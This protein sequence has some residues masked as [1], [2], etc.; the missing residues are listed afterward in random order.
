MNALYWP[1]TGWAVGNPDLKPETSTEYECIFRKFFG[2]TGDIK[3]VVFEKRAKDLIQWQ[4]ISPG[5]W[6]PVNVSKTRIRGF[7]T[8]GKIH[9][10]TADV[11]LSYTFMD[12]QDITADKKIRFSTRHQIKGTASVYPAKDTTVSIEWSYVTNYVVQKGDP[13]CYFLLNGK[14]SRK[15]RLSKGTAEI[16]IIGKN[17]LNRDFETITGYP[18]PPVEFSGGIDSVSDGY[19]AKHIH[20]NHDPHNGDCLCLHHCRQNHGHVRPRPCKPPDGFII[21]RNDS[22]NACCLIHTSAVRNKKENSI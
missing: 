20:L 1:D 16:F 14:L 4:E 17:I 13:E 22:Q 10:N 15:V 5:I 21:Q 2:N 9:I 19:Q 11:G 3:L 7:E 18:M 12:P 8:E 6:S